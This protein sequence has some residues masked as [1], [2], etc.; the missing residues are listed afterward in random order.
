M[1]ISVRDYRVSD[2]PAVIGLFQKDFPEEEIFETDL[3]L[4]EYIRWLRITQGWAFGLLRLL[5]RLSR[6]G[7][8]VLVAEVDGKVVGTLTFI[9]QGHVVEASAALVDPAYRQ[10]GVASALGEEVRHRL[11]A[12]K[13]YKYAR[14]TVKQTNTASLALNQ[15]FGLEV[16]DCYTEYD[17]PLPLADNGQSAAAEIMSRPRRSADQLALE[18]LV[19]RTLPAV[20]EIDGVA[21]MN[22]LVGR[23]YNYLIG[24]KRFERVYEQQGRVVGLM[25]VW[26]D[27]K[28]VK[29]M[30]VRPYCDDVPGLYDLMRQE[31]AAWAGRA[32]K[33]ILRVSEAGQVQVAPSQNPVVVVRL[34]RRL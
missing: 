3:T 33:T 16:Y 26:A 10:Q 14:A 9:G 27:R 24:T 6:V 28:S 7:G 34:A 8:T 20:F 30:M 29:G 15:H 1:A 13:D 2:L 22:V 12:H 25:R 19:R 18:A 5:A 23:V 17:L 11:V 21:P 4:E 32:G 31:A